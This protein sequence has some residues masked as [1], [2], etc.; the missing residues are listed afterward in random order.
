MSFSKQPTRQFVASVPFHANIFTYTTSYNAQTA[1]TTGTLS[2]VSGATAA[3]CP[4]GRV[5]RENGKKL[6]PA[7]HPGVS[8]YM[9]GVI[10]SITFMFGYIDPDSPVFAVSNTDVPAFYANPVDPV[11]SRADASDPVY[12]NGVV[13]SKGQIRNIGAAGQRVALD[14]TQAS[15]VIDISQ[16][17]FVYIEGNGTNTLTVGNFNFGDRMYLQCGA[18]TGNVIF[19]TGFAVNTNNFAKDRLMMTFICDGFHMVEQS[20]SQWLL[21][22]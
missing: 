4:S 7:A 14:G 11:T 19:S 10:D 3:N 6:F 9:V 21:T 22:Y 20:R 17:S 2:S 12:T 5:L 15:L 13:V 18:N 16:G 8:T 1:V